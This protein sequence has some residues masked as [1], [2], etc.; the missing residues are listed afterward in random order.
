MS[1][2]RKNIAMSSKAEH[3]KREKLE[4]WLGSFG[5]SYIW[6]GDELGGFRKGGYERYMGSE[7]FRA[8]IERLMKIA[9]KRR[10]CIMCLEVSSKRCHRRFISQ[11]LTS[12]GVKVT[13]ILSAEKII[14]EETPVECLKRTYPQ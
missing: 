5:I 2:S 10:A 4:G 9:S 12:M 13:H 1:F 3:F 6:L 11:R 14:Y 7:G 8:G